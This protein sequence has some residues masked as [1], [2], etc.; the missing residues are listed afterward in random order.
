MAL[1]SMLRRAATLRRMQLAAQQ[2][3]TSAG[4]S[5][6]SPLQTGLTP[7]TTASTYKFGPSAQWITA[8]MMLRMRRPRAAMSVA[9][10]WAVRFFS[11]A[12]L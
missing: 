7:G 5:A 1:G 3:H 6:A 9:G 4:R 2:M 11:P 8:G 10:R 12:R